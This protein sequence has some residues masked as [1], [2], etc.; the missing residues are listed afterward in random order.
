MPSL[1]AIFLLVAQLTKTKKTVEF[2]LD[3]FNVK[4]SRL[5]GAVV[6][7]GY[8]APKYELCKSCDYP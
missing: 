7:L 6:A 8:L 2:W 5:G 4:D 3:R 1:S